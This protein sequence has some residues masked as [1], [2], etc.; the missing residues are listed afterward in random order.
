MKTISVTR[1][2][3]QGTKQV[4]PNSFTVLEY[5]LDLHEFLDDGY[6]I[7]TARCFRVAAPSSKLQAPQSAAKYDALIKISE[8]IVSGLKRSRTFVPAT[9]LLLR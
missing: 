9:T 1:W 5:H 7:N 3:E 4:H 6:L 8:C 2:D